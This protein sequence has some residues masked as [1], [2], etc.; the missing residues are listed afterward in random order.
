MIDGTATFTM[1]AS[2]MII[3]TPRL[4][5]TRPYHRRALFSVVMK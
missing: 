4:T 1:V 3:E 5:A 2:T